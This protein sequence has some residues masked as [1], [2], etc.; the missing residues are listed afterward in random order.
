MIGSVRVWPSGE[1][2]CLTTS[3]GYAD[4]HLTK[5]A[6]LD[7]ASRWAISH[8]PATVLLAGDDLEQIVWTCQ[9]PSGSNTQAD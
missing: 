8:R 3:D 1:R 5:Q 4:W 6:A 7:A 2:W 9:P